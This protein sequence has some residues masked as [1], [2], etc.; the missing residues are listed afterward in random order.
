MTEWFAQSQTPPL[1]IAQAHEGASAAHA[2][3]E[4]DAPAVPGHDTPATHASTAAHAETGAAHEA[5]SPIA[6]F[7][8][9]PWGFFSYAMV[10]FLA[11]VV[12]AVAATRKMRL[13][14]RGLQNFMELVVEAVYG[15]PE[16]V[17][18]P[19]GRHYAPFVGTIFLSILA[20]N[21]LGLVPPFRSGTANLSITAGLALVSFVAVQYFG[22]RA[23][24]ARY[25][26]HFFGPVPM[27]NIPAVILGLL[28]LP[29][30]LLA[31]LI[32]PVSLSFRLYGNIFGEE[33]VVE[34]L[35]RQF[36]AFPPVL[37]LPLQL[38]TSVL[39]ALVFS[40]LVTVYIALATEKHD[41][42][43]DEHAEASAH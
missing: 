38:L 6:T 36:G 8:H 35:A 9:G 21:L 1:R 5:H 43:H 22:F 27:T 11:L 30:E 20:M 15:I 24:G 23:H 3:P 33:Q 12:L 31:E 14:P 17:M 18:G 40:L 42:H 41:E 2:A 10:A 13:I 39:Q 26:M 28:L 16:M 37:L 34:A 7:L 19:R 25:L 32:R 29:L 4:H